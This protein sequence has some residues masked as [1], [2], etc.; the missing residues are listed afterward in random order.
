M[1]GSPQVP[2]ATRPGDID[3]DD[4]RAARAIGTLAHELRNAVGSSRCLLELVLDRAEDQLEPALY[5]DLR[6]AHTAVVDALGIIEQQLDLAT[7]RAGRLRSH[8]ADVDVAAIL[9]EL[10]TTYHAMRRDEAVALVVEPVAAEV[11]TVRTDARLLR[12]ILRN[13]LTNA[14]KFTD[15]GEVRLAVRPGPGRDE[16]TVSVSDTGIGIAFEDQRWIFDEFAQVDA[17]QAGRPPGTGLGL[18]FVRGVCAHLGGRLELDSEPG[19][20]STFRVTL[21]RGA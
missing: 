12:Q 10:T 15:A 1:R 8:A 9:G 5:D 20:G 21:P 3:D 7:L 2:Q 13:L 17:V 4:N 14:L 6:L 18:P 16:V 11:A 19:R